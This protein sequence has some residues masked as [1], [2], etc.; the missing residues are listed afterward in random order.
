MN[1]FYTYI[2]YS[3]N[4][5]QYYIGYTGDSLD[6]RI[7]KHNANHKGFTGRTKDW[8]IAYYE[9]FDNKTDALKREKQ[10]KNWK[11]KSMIIKLIR[12]SR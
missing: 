9:T 1:L 10:I 6:N 3:E 12:A 2:L 7:K 5:N 11:S 4:L 8:K